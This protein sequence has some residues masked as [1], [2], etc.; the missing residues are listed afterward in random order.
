[1]VAEEEEED[2]DETAED[3]ELLELLEADDDVDDAEA[4]RVS[5]PAG[6]AVG[7]L[8]KGPLT[9]VLVGGPLFLWL[10]WTHRWSDLRRLPVVGGTIVM[11]LMTAPW[12]LL[13]ELKTP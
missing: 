6:L 2:V 5:E 8:A 9:F 10:L 3:D 12:Y 13:A 7:L 4:D 11:L 1:M